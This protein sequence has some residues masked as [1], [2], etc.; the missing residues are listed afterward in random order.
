MYQN[1]CVSYNSDHFKRKAKWYKKIASFLE[2]LDFMIKSINKAIENRAEKQ[3]GGLL[4]CLLKRNLLGRSHFKEFRLN[5]VYA[6]N[7]FSV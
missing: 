6:R 7:Y 3:I 2:D 4:Y 1:I 5:L